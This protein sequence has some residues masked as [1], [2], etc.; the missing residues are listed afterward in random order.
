SQNFLP[1]QR[2]HREHFVTDDT[3]RL[4]F[5]CCSG[6]AISCQS[7]FLNRQKYMAIVQ[8]SDI[9]PILVPDCDNRVTYCC[10][11]VRK[12]WECKGFATDR[13]CKT[14]RQGHLLAFTYTI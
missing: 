14:L 9:C 8:V 4:L 10:G 6:T 2:C 1:G 7:V 12:W 11:Y 13:V 5:F 3:W